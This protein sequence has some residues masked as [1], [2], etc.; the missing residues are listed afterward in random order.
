M[1]RINGTRLPYETRDELEWQEGMGDDPTGAFP[2]PDDLIQGYGGDDT[3]RGGDGNDVL[4]GNFDPSRAR[5]WTTE[6]QLFYQN[7]EGDR[8]YGG[9]GNDQLY[10]GAGDDFL[11][12]GTGDDILDGGDGTDTADYSSTEF[13]VWVDLLGGYA[14]DDGSI[15]ITDRL[16]SVE[17]VWGS[18]FADEI[19]SNAAINHLFGFGGDDYFYAGPGNDFYDGGNGEDEVDY[20]GARGAVSVNLSTGLAED[21]FGFVDTLISI[22]VVHGSAYDDVL[23][24]GSS[25]SALDGDLG[26][27]RLIGSDGRDI[28]EGGDGN[29][30]LVGGSGNDTLAGGTGVDHM[31]GGLGHDIYG[32]E[33]S[34]DIVVE[35]VGNGT[36]T[37]KARLSYTLPNNVENLTLNGSGNIN[38]RGNT[39]NNV[40]IGNVGNNQLNG[41]A[42][43]DTMAGGAGD[44]IYIVDNAGDVV[45]EGASAGTDVVRS[46]VTYAIGSNVENLELTTSGNISGTGNALANAI[47]GNGGNNNINGGLGNDGLTGGGG[48]DTFL[49]DSALSASN[50]D[51]VADFNASS[52]KIALDRTVFAAITTLGTLAASAFF[53]GA[54]AHDANDRIIYN[55]VSGNL[56]YDS[57]GTGA[58]AAV[59]FATLTGTPAIANTNFNVVA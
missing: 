13:G 12:G 44:D 29:D 27:D 18:E 32:V 40:L 46:S 7:D 47:T 3:L 58:N 22:S 39:L 31:N 19:I 15:F 37:V 42:G 10:G 11:S 8:L 48:Q 26:N 57:D 9:A 4:Y 45:T 25:G 56:F 5:R 38:G 43:A 24:G 41:F 34:G 28:L 54:A 2:N 6:P 30:V 1:A 55:P 51:T 16:T 23:T 50:V 53:Q 59:R 52:E 49:F 17:D 36:D 33:N 35:G 14:T 20:V 21:G